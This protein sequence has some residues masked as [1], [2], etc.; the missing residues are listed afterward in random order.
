F[1]R[2][3]E[4]AAQE[5]FHVLCLNTKHE[6]LSSHRISVGSL[7]ASLVH[8][9]EVFRPAVKEA[10]AAILLV[11]NHPSGDPTPSRQ[12]LAITERLE[13]AGR[14]LGIDVLDHIIVA[15]RG[16]LS[17]REYR[18]SGLTSSLGG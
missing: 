3:A 5:E 7:D 6:V 17:L 4:N 2:L 13:E 18:Q 15:R 1:A 16:H 9:R 11:H 8:P 12:D 10:A 14:T